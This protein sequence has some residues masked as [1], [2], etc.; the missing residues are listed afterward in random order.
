ME[1]QEDLPFGCSICGSKFK[2]SSTLSRHRET[3]AQVKKPI[4][5]LKIKII[6]GSCVISKVD[7]PAQRDP[8]S[9]DNSPANQ[10]QE[11][12]ENGGDAPGND[13][14]SA[15]AMAG[16]SNKSVIENKPSEYMVEISTVECQDEVPGAENDESAVANNGDTAYMISNEGV[17]T[18]SDGAKSIVTPFRERKDLNV[19][20]GEQMEVSNVGHVPMGADPPVIGS[21]TSMTL[22]IAMSNEPNVTSASDLVPRLPSVFSVN[23]GAGFVSSVSTNESNFVPTESQNT[24]TPDADTASPVSVSSLG[25]RAGNTNSFQYANSSIDAHADTGLKLPILLPPTE[26]ML[27]QQPR[28]QETVTGSLDAASDAQMVTVAPEKEPTIKEIKH[29]VKAAH[30]QQ[31]L[32]FE[33]GLGMSHAASI[34]EITPSAQCPEEIIEPSKSEADEFSDS[35][36]QV[37]EPVKQESHTS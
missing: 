9:R 12:T 25:A 3:H 7:S 30:A 21:A 5:K 15:E 32:L 33:S 13:A 27:Q 31:D 11:K 4:K 35:G 16:V 29:E 19:G 34:I 26:P 1:H 17:Y 36:E 28:G 24:P 14:A 23:D 20:D 8:D 10:T 2:S 22:P 6:D 37:G 18:F